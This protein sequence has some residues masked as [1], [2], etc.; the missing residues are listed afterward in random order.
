M[1]SWHH[2]YNVRARRNRNGSHCLPNKHTEHN[3][4]GEGSR[5]CWSYY[6]AAILRHE[7]VLGLTSSCFFFSATDQVPY[8][9]NDALLFRLQQQVLAQQSELEKCAVEMQQFPSNHNQQDESQLETMKSRVH[10][11]EREISRL[12]SQHEQDAEAM[13]AMAQAHTSTAYANARMVEQTAQ[14]SQQIASA[15]MQSHLASAHAVIMNDQVN[16][17]IVRQSTNS[18]T[19]H[20]AD[21]ADGA[22]RND[23]RVRRRM[24]RQEIQFLRSQIMHL[25]RQHDEGMLQQARRDEKNEQ[26]MQRINRNI[27]RIASTPYRRHVHNPVAEDASDLDQEQRIVATLSKNPRTLQALAMARI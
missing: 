15:C 27:I 16:T 5:Y 20:G 11:Y 3:Q 8:H 13:A 14:L 24:E 21:G 18:K 19:D 10:E 1:Q 12:K 22:D 17:H 9:A 26:L 6:N 25:R 4:L 2:G 23:R 7:L